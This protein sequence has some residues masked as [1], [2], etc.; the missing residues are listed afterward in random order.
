MKYLDGSVSFITSETV[1][2]FEIAGSISFI[3]NI[4]NQEDIKIARRCLLADK[5]NSLRTSCTRRAS[6]RFP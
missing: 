5:A 1:V 2:E 4:L 3:L 6:R